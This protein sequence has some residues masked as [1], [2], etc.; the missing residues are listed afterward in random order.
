[1]KPFAAV[2]AC[3]AAAS[4]F[5]VN[6]A[7][8]ETIYSHIEFAATNF[9][10]SSGETRPDVGPVS[11]TFGLWFD[12]ELSYPL[13]WTA[14][15][16]L[17]VFTINPGMYAGMHPTLPPAWSF[18]PSS[19]LFVTLNDQ[20]AYT[21]TLPTDILTHDGA[22]V[23]TGRG[24]VRW[25]GVGTGVFASSTISYQVTVVPEPAMFGMFG[26]GVLGLGALAMRRRSL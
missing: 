15:D 7:K 6:Q 25:E 14:S 1:M 18:E 9:I 4:M 17:T 12:P 8:A 16:G 3:L 10:G 19:G 26:I 24:E 21:V 20:S 2:A 5:V 22:G 13:T 23:L 11:G